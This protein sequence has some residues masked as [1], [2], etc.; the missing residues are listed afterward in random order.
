MQWAREKSLRRGAKKTARSIVAY[1]AVAAAALLCEAAFAASAPK[2]AITIDSSNFTS[3]SIPAQGSKM[4]CYE[5]GGKR[6]FGTLKGSTTAQFKANPDPKK[7]KADLKTKISNFGKQIK[8][9]ARQSKA[10]VSAKAKAKANKQLEKIRKQRYVA[11]LDRYAALKCENPNALLNL[12]NNPAPI[13]VATSPC[14]DLDTNGIFDEADN[15]LFLNGMAAGTLDFNRDGVV[16]YQDMLAF[17]KAGSD[18]EANPALVCTHC[19]EV[20][21]QRYASE[22]ENAETCGIMNADSA[23]L[24]ERVGPIVFYPFQF[25]SPVV[26]F[27]VVSDGSKAARVK[28]SPIYTTSDAVATVVVL[29]PDE[30]IIYWDQYSDPAGSAPET[31]SGSGIEALLP[32][33]FAL[34]KSGVYQIRIMSNQNVQADLFLKPQTKYGYSMQN[35]GF[36]KQNA[37]TMPS[38]MYAWAPVHR[39]RAMRLKLTTSSNLPLPAVYDLTSGSALASSALVVP[40]DESLEGH[41]WRFTFP[42]S[43]W[44]FSA[45]GFPLILSPDIEGAEAIRASVERINSGPLAGG[46]VAHKFQVELAT[47]L[48]LMLAHAGNAE[49]LLNVPSPGSI[50]AC[51][52]P[53]SSDD[54]YKNFDLLGYYSGVVT[55]ARW[56]LL[57]QPGTN[58][59]YQIV[60]PTSPWAGTIGTPLLGKQ[61]CSI[62]ADCNNG[63]SCVNARCAEA[64][65]PAKDRWDVLR[66]S[67]YGSFNNPSEQRSLYAGPSISSGVPLSM[68]FCAVTSTPCNPWGPS[69]TEGPIRYPELLYRA[70]AAAVADIMDLGE[71]SIPRGI[72]SDDNT[73]PG[74]LGF[75]FGNQLMPVFRVAAPHLEET[76]SDLYCGQSVGRRIKRAWA[77]GLR[78]VADRAFNEYI[79]SA[80]NQSSH[81]LTGYQEFA[82]GAS[83]LPFQ[84][85]YRQQARSFAKRFFD[86]ASPAGYFQESAGPD[87]SYN[88]MTHWHLAT[89]YGLTKLDSLGADAGA[90]DAIESSYQF[91][92][93][94]AA[95]ERDG[96]S[97]GACGFGHRIGGG[98]HIEQW[99]GAKGIA[100]DVPAVSRWS[101][102]ITVSPSAQHT[103]LIS[104]ANSLSAYAPSAHLYSL[105]STP[106]TYLFL[107]SAQRS[108]SAVMP[109]NESGSYI[110]NL[111]DELIAVKKPAYFTSIYVGK[112]APGTG[113][114][115]K[116]EELRTALSFEDHDPA[117]GESIDLYRVTPF[118]GGGMSL[119]WNPSYGNSIMTA[120]WSPLTHHGLVAV[121]SA[122]K[123]YWEN[124]FS[125]TFTLNSGANELTVNGTVDGSNLA[126]QRRYTFFDD[127]VQVYL[128]LT[129]TGSVSLS[130]LFENI[131]LATCSRANCNT[132][133]LKNRKSFGA[134]IT[135]NAGTP[136][137]GSQSLNSFAVYDDDF[138][139]MQVNLDSTRTIQA[140]QHGLRLIQYSDEEQI[141]RVQ[142]SLPSSF[143]LGQTHELTYEIWPQ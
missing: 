13:Q 68:A 76:M 66:S 35:G 14:P 86:S 81:F 135:D 93:H 89:Y 118:L 107:D 2:R 47:L 130:S 42:D 112:P 9:L 75:A 28:L 37:S 17:W 90:Y 53:S 59:P 62:N 141:G 121:T 54:Y 45:S 134:K 91:F 109:A 21:K 71:D 115:P 22:C 74:V 123:R 57:K 97:M 41:I 133:D 105:G 48:P 131:P 3:F 83:N 101:D 79:V 38:T 20:S 51:V 103:A 40:S 46:L 33:A 126:Y 95:P 136:I 36:G 99:G 30:N 120:N 117:L 84:D 137:S 56:G 100:E 96:R 127:H 129:A 65:D 124:Y 98:S 61:V 87:A 143:S 32:E 43:N 58:L 60:D 104:S 24:T 23:E 70:T 113:Y 18:F 122:A 110:R 64:F 72:G 92:N 31:H 102:E 73:Y 111:G 11:Q 116:I 82:M 25:K 7:F 67:T 125:T 77:N 52:N 119:F 8:I 114:L 55:A 16:D 15:T 34:P 10:R 29:D 69:T 44:A 128:K 106:A 85:F 26:T 88:G 1:C 139:G 19:A 12:P 140:F 132:A 39:A 108:S 63:S 138:N 4:V 78:L 94:T 50:D 6:Y 142:I 49:D 5:Q 27:Y 80:A